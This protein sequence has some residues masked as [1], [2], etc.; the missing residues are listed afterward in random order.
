[1][2]PRVL[3][4]D[5]LSP[6]GQ[7][8]LRGGGRTEVVV[9]DAISAPELL[10]SI[11]DFDAVVVRSRTKI[12]REVLER[13]ERLRVVGRC[14]VG[15]DNIDVE[16]ARARGVAVVTAAG[17]TAVSVAELTMAL[18]LCLARRIPA[19]DASTRAGGWDR[20]G[21]EGI[22]IAGKTLSILGLG[23]I[24]REV[25]ARAA[26]FG[27][28]VL[29]HDPYLPAHLRVLAGAE[30]RE[31]SSLIESADIL[32]VHVPLLPETRHLIGREALARMRRGAMIVNV[33]RGGI[34]D[35]A[36]LLAA[37]R[38]GQIA[39]A[40]LDVFE[41][42][43]PSGTELLREPRIVVTPHIGAS[44]A[45]AQE[46]AGLEVARRVLEALPTS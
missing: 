37:V 11:A 46:R 15:L 32:T 4:A 34:V 7:E 5:P 26:A 41:S 45:E 44:T 18:I 33:A 39:G 8:I 10:A 42:E 38:A 1:M 12:T 30:E 14:G 6:A 16:T 27:M 40:A 24:G 13:G 36:A 31:F 23:N 9:R 29:F 20:K 3:I 43:P 28:R 17:A 2:A 35:E 25:A 19:A 21:F 22:E